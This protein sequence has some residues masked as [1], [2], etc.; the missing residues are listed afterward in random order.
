LKNELYLGNI[1]SKEGFSRD[2][3]KLR[4]LNYDFSKLDLN[5]GVAPLFYKNLNNFKRIKLNFLFLRMEH[6]TLVKKAIK[7]M[8][9]NQNNQVIQSS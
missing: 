8:D 7:K 2:S 3:A 1:Q 5:Y 4:I 6:Y 9:K